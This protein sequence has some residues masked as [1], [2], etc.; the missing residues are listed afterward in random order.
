MPRRDLSEIERAKQEVRERVWALLERE[1]AVQPPGAHGR[2]PNFVGA[3][4]AA[5]QLATLPAWQAAK[6]IKANPDK[7]Q[8]PVRVHALTEGKLLYMAVPRLADARPFYLLDPD[9]LRVS[10]WDAASSRGA[11]TA[12]RKV[13][14]DDL[15]PVDLV[16]CG[17]VAV[18]REGVRVGKGGGFS[19]L[20]VALLLEA[21]LLGPETILVTTVHALQVG[22]EVLPETKHDF[23][24]DLVVTPDE[25]IWCP[26]HPQPPGILWKHLDETKIAEVPVLDDM[27]MSAHLPHA[28]SD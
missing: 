13:T 25:V 7:A 23:R 9:V 6:V 8:L 10:P 12:A 15:R 28:G 5:E 20:E 4:A 1:N 21:G 19:D 2:I 26:P 14:V 11:A 3:D 16:V 24:V 27:R 18:N 22:D 17:T